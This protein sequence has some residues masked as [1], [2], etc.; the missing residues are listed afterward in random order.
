[1]SWATNPGRAPRTGE[2]PL[3]VKFANGRE[4][5]HAYA[6]NQLRWSL[7]GSEWDISEV[8]RA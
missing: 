5:I 8:A 1:M 4:S 2:R 3:R 6:A 7:T